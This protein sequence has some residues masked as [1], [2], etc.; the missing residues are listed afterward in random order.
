M[1][2]AITMAVTGA[3]KMEQVGAMERIGDAKDKKCGVF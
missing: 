2:F 3:H 1:V